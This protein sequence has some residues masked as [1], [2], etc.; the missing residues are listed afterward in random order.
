MLF[1]A[2]MLYMLLAA[3]FCFYL[4]AVGCHLFI[5]NRVNQNPSRTRKY[6]YYIYFQ[7]WKEYARLYPCS[8]VR[9]FAIAFSVGTFAFGIAAVLARV[10]ELKTGK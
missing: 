10:V 9:A 4:G 2:S 6:G 8:K 3:T 5:V 1:G 7:G